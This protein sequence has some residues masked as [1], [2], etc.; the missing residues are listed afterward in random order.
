M[1]CTQLF[2]KAVM[3]NFPALKF[4]IKKK[5]KNQEKERFEKESNSCICS[6]PFILE[7]LKDMGNVCM[8]KSLKSSYVKMT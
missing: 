2:V 5:K 3:E 1:Y 4:C 6:V 8:D 7:F